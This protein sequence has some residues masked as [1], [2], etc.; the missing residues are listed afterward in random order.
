[1]GKPVQIFMPVADGSLRDYPSTK[2][3]KKEIVLVSKQIIS[4]LQYLHGKG[5]VHGNI[6]LENILYKNRTTGLTFFWP[7][8]AMQRELTPR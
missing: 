2:M 1:M 3:E 8:L 4:A 6:K 5:F 7:T